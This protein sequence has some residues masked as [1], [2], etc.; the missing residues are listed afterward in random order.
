MQLP[1]VHRPLSS[2]LLA[3]GLI[4]LAMVLVSDGSI[5]RAA[6]TGAFFGTFVGIARWL[7]LSGGK[8]RAGALE[9]ALGTGAAAATAL[10]LLFLVAAGGAGDGAWVP[11]LL[12]LAGAGAV[13]L[14]GWRRWHRA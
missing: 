4:A 9:L 11:W 12:L 6:G 2:G 5:L 3:G 10:V 8:R 14:H 1:W 13:A 7:E